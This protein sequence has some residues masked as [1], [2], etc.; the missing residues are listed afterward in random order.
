MTRFPAFLV[1]LLLLLA[2]CSQAT[3]LLDD[4][5]L[6]DNSLVTGEPCI[7]P[8]FRG[9]TP[10]ETTWAD[11]LTIIEDDPE[12]ENV[13]TQGPEEGGTVIQVSWQQGADAP[14]CCQ[15]VTEDGETV[16][17][18]FLR[19]APVHSVADLFGAH[20]EPTWLTGQEFPDEQAVMSLVYPEVPMIVYAFV[21]GA[22]E[23]VLNAG[24]E[25]VGTLY[26]APGAMELLLQTTNLHLWEGYGSYSSYM[27]GDWEVTPSVTLTPTP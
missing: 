3:V 2:A 12:F 14:G 15:M 26:L 19:T 27:D 18:V 24:S 7:A 21:E 4:N 9:I 5:L 10:G 6:R 13:Q 8:C 1:A 11:A 16:A 23:G 20:G 22:A 17:L 25:L